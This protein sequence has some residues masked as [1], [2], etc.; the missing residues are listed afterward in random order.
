MK[1]KNLRKILTIFVCMII[2]L[3]N[4]CI[5]SKTF[6]NSKQLEQSEQIS[7]NEKDTVVIFFEELNI[8]KDKYFPLSFSQKDT[9]TKIFVTKNIKSIEVDSTYKIDTDS[10]YKKF[11]IEK[12]IKNQ[13]I[14]DSL[15]MRKF[16]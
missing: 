13:I 5:S 4:S 2:I 11:K 16:K 14:S 8:K 15:L 3:Y 7:L 10:S 9:I 1:N 12:N 6:V